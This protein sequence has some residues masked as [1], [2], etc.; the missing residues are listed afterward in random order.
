LII[1]EAQNLP[2]KTIE[3]IRM[4]SNLESESHHLLQIILIGQPELKNKLRRKE[5]KQ[6]AQRVT[7]YCHLGGLSE[8]EV[9]E[10]IHHRLR[11]AGAENVD[12]FNK[13]AVEAVY[14]YSRGIPRIINILCD[15]A[16][17]YGY[18]DERKTVDR[19][20]IVDVVKARKEGGF[21]TGPTEE[22]ER[23]PLSHTEKTKPLMQLEK[24]LQSIEQRINL[25]ERNVSNLEA[26]LNDWTHHHAK[27]DH[28]IFELF[29]MVRE[30]LE[31]RKKMIL[32]YRKLKRQVEMDRTKTARLVPFKEKKLKS[33]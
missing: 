20:V 11:V 15:T 28:V 8:E 32:R 2:L 9:K 24:R 7:V 6:F 16:L 5:L 29:K 1:D 12:L 30:N 27:K 14:E 23:V 21:F 19:K 26:Q 13:E 33:A 22:K 25:F 10:Y 17:L 3:A 31:G 4:L 18:A